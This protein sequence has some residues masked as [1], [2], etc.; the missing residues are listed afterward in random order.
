[1]GYNYGY[2]QAGYGKARMRRVT[3]MDRITLWK[4]RRRRK[5]L[6]RR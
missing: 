6:E 3:L 5:A 4:E 2:F 1:M